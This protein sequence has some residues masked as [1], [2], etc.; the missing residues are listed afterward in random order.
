MVVMDVNNSWSRLEERLAEYS[1]LPETPLAPHPPGR[2]GSPQPAPAE[3]PH[4][5]AR[6]QRPLNTGV[7]QHRQPKTAGV[8]AEWSH[9]TASNS[10]PSC[11]RVG[12]SLSRVGAGQMARLILFGGFEE[13]GQFASNQ[14]E[15]FDPSAMRWCTPA[16]RGAV[17]GRPPAPRAG[18]SASAM[19]RHHLIVFGG[20][21]ERGRSPRGHWPA[22]RGGSDARD[23]GGALRPRALAA[24]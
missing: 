6:I 8:E 2:P 10:G 17:R 15:L 9:V 11:A 22:V 19:G 16:E 23:G 12:A 1:A 21:G 3:V 4:L 24:A 20:R 13:G 14:V 18:H 7:N 5:S